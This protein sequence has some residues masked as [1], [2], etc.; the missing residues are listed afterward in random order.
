[1]QI[2]AAHKDFYEGLQCEFSSWPA[3]SPTTPAAGTFYVISCGQVAL[4][5]K[6]TQGSM[7]L[8]A[9]YQQTSLPSSLSSTSF[10]FLYGKQFLAKTVMK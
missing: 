2:N 3:R 5:D 6:V 7:L 1:M 9:A 4:A 10:S 8:S